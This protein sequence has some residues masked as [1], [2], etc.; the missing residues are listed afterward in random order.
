MRACLLAIVLYSLLQTSF[1]LSVLC[2]PCFYSL[3]EDFKLTLIYDPEAIVGEVYVVT[4]DYT[5][6]ANMTVH[7]ITVSIWTVEDSDYILLKEVTLVSNET[8]EVG[9]SVRR[10][11]ALT[12]PSTT[13]LLIKVFVNYTK[14][15]QRTF[16]YNVV[17]VVRDKS[18]SDLVEEVNSLK[19]QIVNLSTQLSELKVELEKVKAN[20]SRVSGNYSELRRAY[21]DLKRM[22]DNLLKSYENKTVE[23]ERLREFHEVLI[24]DYG[25]LLRKYDEL[26]T[27]FDKAIRDYLKYRHKYDELSMRYEKLIE[28]VDVLA[29]RCVLIGS[30]TTVL[31]VSLILALIYIK[32]IKSLLRAKK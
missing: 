17:V 22:Y 11:V 12:V 15:D 24:E 6:L 29:Q 21:E 9:W 30:I 4:V 13:L 25:E 16:N 18:Y 1:S 14:R 2:K 19:S 31:G 3:T 5:S 23:L 20:Y 7:E 8:V 27:G 10:T 28:E 26:S 32:R